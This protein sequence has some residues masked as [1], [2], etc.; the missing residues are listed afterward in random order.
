MKSP[1]GGRS[2]S[3]SGWGTKTP[4][5]ANAVAISERDLVSALELEDRACL[6]RGRDFEAKSFDDL[7]RLRDLG[8]IR[9]GQL[10]GADP[11][12]VLEADPHV[13]AHRGRHRGDRHLIAARSQHRPMIVL[14]PEQ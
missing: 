10:A 11:Q 13:A 14:A 3:S 9:L 5:L 1:S 7:A 2:P 6:V 4:H 8:G 12:R